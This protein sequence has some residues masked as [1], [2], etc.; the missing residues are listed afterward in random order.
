MQSSRSCTISQLKRVRDVLEKF[1]DAHGIG[2][3]NQSVCRRITGMKRSTCPWITHQ[4]RTLDVK[5]V[6]SALDTLRLAGNLGSHRRGQQD[7]IAGKAGCQRQKI[8]SSMQLLGI[9]TERVFKQH[10]Y[11]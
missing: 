3:K 6:Q 10:V 1:L 7:Y 11:N 5:H 4:G 9:P 2:D 8:W